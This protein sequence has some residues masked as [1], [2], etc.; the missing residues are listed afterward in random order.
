MWVRSFPARPNPEQP[1]TVTE[2]SG[3]RLGRF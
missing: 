2:S 1:K 3:S